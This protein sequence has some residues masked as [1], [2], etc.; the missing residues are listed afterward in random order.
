M[1]TLSLFQQL[2]A[3]I[4]GALLAIGLQLSAQSPHSLHSEVTVS[5]GINAASL[6]YAF[7][8]GKSRRHIMEAGVMMVSR[9]PETGSDYSGFDLVYHFVLNTDDNLNFSV[10]IGGYGADFG[11]YL[12]IPLTFR[13][14]FEEHF[15]LRA[16]LTSLLG[17]AE[18][19]KVMPTIGF[20]VAF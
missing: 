5:A 1:K 12:V 6:D 17:G 2:K 18:T 13:Y 9:D 19:V 16:R 10:G 20:G 8:F 7:C 3:V 14:K 4:L 11:V 15:R